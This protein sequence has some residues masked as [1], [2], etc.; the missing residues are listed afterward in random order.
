MV[1]LIAGFVAL[2][3]LS[4]RLHPMM[5]CPKCKGRSRHYGAL[6]GSKFRFCHKCGGSGRA[7][8][9]GAKVLMGV[10]LMKHGPERTGSFGWMWK[11]RNR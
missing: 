5:A 8:R 10:G 2:Y 9:P 4:W 7:V 6:H 11:N 3:A 1:L